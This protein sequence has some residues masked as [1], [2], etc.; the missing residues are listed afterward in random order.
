MESSAKMQPRGANSPWVQQLEGGLS[1]KGWSV[2]D[3]WD[4]AGNA[5]GY[6]APVQPINDTG[7]C[8][9]YMCVRVCICIFTYV[10]IDIYTCTQT[11]IHTYF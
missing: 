5:A 7:M 1:L 10:D 3:S 11:Y 2:G 9:L 6:A 8:F 4:S